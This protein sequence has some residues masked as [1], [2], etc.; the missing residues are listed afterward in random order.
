LFFNPIEMSYQ[1]PFVD[2]ARSVDE[3]NRE[4]T[5]ISY[6]AYGSML[7]L[8]LDLSLRERNLNLDDY[9][10]LMWNNFGKTNTYYTVGDLHQTLN[11]FA[12]KEFGN[13]FFNNYIYKSGMPG[14]EKL[15]E[16]V[17]VELAAM[18]NWVSLGVLTRNHL[19]MSNPMINTTAYIAEL[20]KGDRIIKIADVVLNDS[21]TLD[22]VLENFKS[23]TE[24]KIVFERYGE[25]K[26]KTIILKPDIKYNLALKK[27][28]DARQ[29]E[30][31]ADWLK[32]KE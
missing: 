30:N 21:I 16:N 12:G 25:T 7:G 27:E 9:M 4:N 5:F 3:T 22:K 28:I 29:K 15:F 13:H 19:I 8:A 31:K 17:G 11:Q 10:K 24:V 1:A 26:E 23:G 14:F 20:Q 18:D 2:A 6:Y 32:L